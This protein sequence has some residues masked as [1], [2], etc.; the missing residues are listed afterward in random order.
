[1]FIVQNRR[2][3][4]RRVLKAWFGLEANDHFIWDVCR[5]ATLCLDEDEPIYGND[6][7][8][9]PA[10]YPRLHRELIRAV[11]AV[12]LDI[13]VRRVNLKALDKAY[14]VVF[15]HSTPINVNKKKLID[16]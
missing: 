14:S 12:R 2:Y 7:L 3:C 6:M 13:G 1:M 10:L 11:V 8:R 9:P 15:P 5:Q 16:E 4:P